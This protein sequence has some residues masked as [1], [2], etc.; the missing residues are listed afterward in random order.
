MQGAIILSIWL[1]VTL[2]GCYKMMHWMLETW[3]R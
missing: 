1:P 3:D 2:Y